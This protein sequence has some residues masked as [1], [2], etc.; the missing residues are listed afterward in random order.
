[1]QGLGAC[2]HFN[3]FHI[4]REVKT[5]TPSKTEG[6]R[7]PKRPSVQRGRV[8]HPPLNFAGGRRKPLASARFHFSEGC[9]AWSMTRTSTGA[10]CNSSFSPSC[11]WSAVKI[12]DS[13]DSGD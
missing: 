11:S 4:E 8:C 9:S 12:G 10:C 7:H 13:E 5:R 2:E 3:F 6:M 1:M